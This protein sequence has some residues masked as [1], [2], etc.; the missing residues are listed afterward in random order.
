MG[1]SDI[2]ISKLGMGGSELEKGAPE[3]AREGVRMLIWRYA[4]S[5]AYYKVYT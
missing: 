4:E 5:T 1:Q 2:A 3:C